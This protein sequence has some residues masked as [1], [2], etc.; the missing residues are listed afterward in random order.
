MHL[1]G[2]RR[3]V[4]LEQLTNYILLHNYT[5]YFTIEKS[6]DLQKILAA[7]NN[8]STSACWIM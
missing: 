7:I 1:G 6:D 3:W 5:Q 2:N 8:Y 4:P